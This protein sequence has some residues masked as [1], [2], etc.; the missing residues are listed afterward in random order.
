MCYP[1]GRKHGRYWAVK[2]REFITVLGGAATAWPLAARAQQRSGVRRIGVFLAL[3]TGPEDPGAG[4]ILR[5]LRASMQDVGWT[6]GRNVSFD[7][8]FGGGNL[9]KMS[10][11][12]DELVALA[13]DLIYAT[14]LPP[15]QAL[16]DVGMDDDH[17]ADPVGDDAAVEP[18]EWIGDHR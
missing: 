12:A 7:V 6:E 3:A 2:R 17:G 5:P 9:G 8:R 10:V 4:E 1:F 16:R 13:P 18:V 11:A 15:V 14:G